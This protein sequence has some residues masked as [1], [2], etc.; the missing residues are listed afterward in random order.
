MPRGVDEYVRLTR[1]PAR[2]RATASILFEQTT[3]VR[4]RTCH[5]FLF[6]SDVTAILIQVNG[7]PGAQ[8][9]P[10]A[11]PRHPLTPNPPVS[12]WPPAWP[13]W[14]GLNPLVV[15]IIV[16][17]IVGFLLLAASTKVKIRG[18]FVCVEFAGPA[19]PRRR[20]CPARP[21]PASS[22]SEY[23]RCGPCSLCCCPRQ[24][25][26]HGPVTHANSHGAGV[27]RDGH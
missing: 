6:N 10:N 15:T 8:S 7:T 17:W 14:T 16:L 11:S 27:F 9:L 21:R 22:P 25:M 12:S 20:R 19:K 26:V 2:R 24:D 18:D 4:A 1:H 13:A 5:P 23:R 3:L